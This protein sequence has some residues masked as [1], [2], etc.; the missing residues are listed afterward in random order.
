MK[1]VLVVHNYKMSN[2]D[3]EKKLVTKYQFLEDSYNGVRYYKLH[4][5]KLGGKV[6]KLQK[7]DR[8]F[9]DD[10][11]I[12]LKESNFFDDIVSKHSRGNLQMFPVSITPKTNAKL[13]TKILTK[14]KKIKED[15]N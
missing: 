1:K 8:I 13:K 10:D 15:N 14:I 11:T 4:V 5:I 12:S 2:A 7:Y 3:Y 6:P 9:W